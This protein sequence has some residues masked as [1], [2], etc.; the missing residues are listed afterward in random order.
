MTTSILV[1]ADI[2]SILNRFTAH[3]HHNY[4]NC[5]FV[6]AVGDEDPVR[7]KKYLLQGSDPNTNVYLFSSDSGCSSQILNENE[8]GTPALVYTLMPKKLVHDIGNTEIAK[9]LLEAGANPNSSDF[10][11]NTPLIIASGSG[12]CEMVKLLLVKHADLGSVNKKGFT[13]LQSAQLKH[14]TCI[15]DLLSRSKKY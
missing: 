3:L 11:G 9:L 12:N 13:A 15:V 1:L 14:Y 10:N 4:I 5:E 8:Q 7:I 6:R 2:Y